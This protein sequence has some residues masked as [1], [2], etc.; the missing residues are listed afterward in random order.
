MK[1]FMAAFMLVAA[2]A[3]VM[4]SASPAQDKE[5]KEKTLKGRV[6]CAKCELKLK[7]FTKCATVFVLKKDKKDVIYFFDKA[8]DKKYHEDICAEGKNG[9]VTGIFTKEGKKNIVK[10]KSITYD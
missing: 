10:V 9:T 6:T 1:R 3:L 5:E 7:G 2:G 4:G 8:S